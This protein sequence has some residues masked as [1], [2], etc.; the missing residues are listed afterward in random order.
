MNNRTD[1]T[2]ERPEIIRQSLLDRI[3]AK[4]RTRPDR[5]AFGPIQFDFLRIEDSNVLLDELARQEDDP[6][7]IRARHEDNDDLHLPYWA[8]IWDSA[9]GLSQYLIGSGVRLAGSRVLDLGCGMGLVGTVAAACGANVTLADMEPDALLFAQYNAMRF[10]NAAAVLR[11]DWRSDQ[12]TER[13]DLILGADILY[14]TDQWEA[15]ESFCCRHLQPGGAVL[16]AEPNRP[17]ADGFIT[18]IAGKH[19]CTETTHQ[20]IDKTERS[21]RVIRLGCASG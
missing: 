7:K 3:R 9:I 12:S 19:W 18:W 21:I 16:L 8:E 17:G 5:F 15:I 2:R 4:F 13:F 10:D 6:A 20:L 14:E 11:L 1:V